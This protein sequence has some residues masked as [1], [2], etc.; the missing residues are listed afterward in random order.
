M[1]KVFEA[2]AAFEGWF[3]PPRRK[4]LYRLGWV[5]TGLLGTHGF[6]TEDVGAAWLL[7]IASLLGMADRN[8]AYPA[9]PHWSASDDNPEV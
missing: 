7:A 5:V 4:F 1:T 6:I 9:S 8:V 3:T 2:L